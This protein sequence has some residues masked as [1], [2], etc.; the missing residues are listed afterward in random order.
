ME[1]PASLDL[2]KL[3]YRRLLT[4]ALAYAGVAV[5]V[6]APLV[7]FG[8]DWSER[9]IGLIT[10]LS[11]PFTGLVTLLADVAS[12]RWIFRPI[13]PGLQAIARGEH[14]TPAIHDALERL[15][16]LPRTTF[17]RIALVHTPVG[18]I[19]SA[20]STAYVNNRYDLGITGW[21]MATVSAI[22]LTVAATHSVFEYYAVLQ[23]VRR[24][25]PLVRARAGTLP[26]TFGR[27]LSST[28]IRRRLV[29]IA[30]CMTFAPFVV[31]GTSTVVR[32]NHTLEA[33]G[34]AQTLPQLSPLLVWLS[35]LFGVVTLFAVGMALLLARDVKQ[36]AGDMVTAMEHVEAG[37]LGT[38]LVVTSTDEF[39]ILYRGFNRMV[40]GLRERERLRDAFGRFISPELAEQVLR[41]GVTR[42]GVMVD[43]S[44]LFVDMRDYSALS[45]SLSAEQI[46]TLLNRLFALCEPAIKAEGGW[47]N[48]FLGDGLMVLFGTPAAYPDH[49]RRAVRAARTIRRNLVA[50]NAAQA[51]AGGPPVRI[52]MAIA[53]G[54]M[55]AGSIGSPDRVEYTVVGDV[56]NIAYRLET[57]NKELDTTLLISDSVYEAVQHEVPARAM[58]PMRVK[59]RTQPIRVYA[60]D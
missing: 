59:G 32:V 27:T 52:G 39:A 6:G 37:D 50:F 26:P 15:L 16:N 9:Q 46:V 11:T 47:I 3:L 14:G 5:F 58:P 49:A 42:D 20:L 45:E 8:L 2:E 38:H 21:Q 4:I 34:I 18:V 24:I 51:A 43:A 36:L 40:D 56:V 17:V 28:S 13:R 31:L 19:S 60:I 1:Q 7:L 23:T 29:Y 22:A 12:V 53:S 41:Q 48:K 54:A 33:L 25:I 57:L 44:V 55:V 35:L 30:L 10:R